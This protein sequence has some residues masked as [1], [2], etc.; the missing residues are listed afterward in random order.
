[1]TERNSIVQNPF[2]FARRWYDVDS[3]YRGLVRLEPTFQIGKKTPAIPSDVRS[4][5]F[6][7][8]LAGQ[9]RLAMAKGAELAVAEM[10]EAAKQ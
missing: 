5:E 3:I 4:R 7:E 1:M 6:A 8:W 2:E 10:R 9:Y